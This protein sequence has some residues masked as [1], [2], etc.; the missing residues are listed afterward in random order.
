MTNEEFLKSV[1]L[2][3]ENWKDVNKYEGI[4]CVSNLGR[5]ASLGR[6][7]SAKNN[8]FAW[9]EPRIL[10]EKTTRLGYKEVSLSRN[11]TTKRFFVHRLVALSF[12]PNPL[13]L[14]QIDHID[15]VKS[16]N[17][18]SNLRWCTAKGNMQNPITK[19]VVKHTH[20]GHT[21]IPVVSLNGNTIVKK[22]SSA[23]DATKDG[24]KRDSICSVCTGRRKTHKGYSWMYLS[25]YESLVNQ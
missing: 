14:P 4:Y 9:I 22:Y 12:I 3:G 21:P 8:G 6:Y 17:K 24:F 11:G 18:V 25:D 5:I 1:A 19:Q 20:F 7:K 15:G 13:G 16:N 23:T 2:F 10:K